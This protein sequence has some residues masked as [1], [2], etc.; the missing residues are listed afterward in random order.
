MRPRAAQRERPLASRFGARSEAAVLGVSFSKLLPVLVPAAFRAR[1]T[2]SGPVSAKFLNAA[3]VS[4][5]TTVPGGSVDSF[6][7][8]VLKIS[9]AYGCPM[10]EAPMDSGF[11]FRQVLLSLAACCWWPLWPRKTTTDGAPEANKGRISPKTTVRG[12]VTRSKH[13]SQSQ[14]ELP[15]IRRRRGDLRVSAQRPDAPVR[16]ARRAR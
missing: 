4:L 16:I 7:F 15:L 3:T 1:R 12:A 13:H 6:V 5:T 9:S 11:G 8:G 10:K 2:P 14:P